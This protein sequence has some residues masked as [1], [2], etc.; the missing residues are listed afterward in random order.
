LEG[1]ADRASIKLQALASV[2]YE[3]FTSEGIPSGE[4]KHYHVGDGDF[5]PGPGGAKQNDGGR[6]P[7]G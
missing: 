5:I 4:I 2:T 3:A 6:T 7:G 1:V